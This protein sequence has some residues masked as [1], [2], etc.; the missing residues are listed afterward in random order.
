MTQNNTKFQLL[1]KNNINFKN[2][3]FIYE[4]SI[5]LKKKKRCDFQ[6]RAKFTTKPG[7]NFKPKLLFIIFHLRLHFKVGIVDGCLQTGFIIGQ[8]TNQR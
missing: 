6:F 3:K 4:L 2:H 7:E 8:I 1:T 5:P